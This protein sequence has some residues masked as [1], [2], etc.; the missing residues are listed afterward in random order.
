MQCRERKRDRRLEG[1]K[2]KVGHKRGK[3]MK[4]RTWEKGEENKERAY[5]KKRRERSERL[6]ELGRKVTKVRREKAMGEK[7]RMR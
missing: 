1:V 3:Q 7:V 2:R 5:V 4:R 6:R